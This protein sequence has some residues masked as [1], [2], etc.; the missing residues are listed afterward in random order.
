MR[1]VLAIAMAALLGASCGGGSGGFTLGPEA[2]IDISPTIITFG[3][4]PRGEV[5][6]RNITV[7]HIGTS[8][9]IK[10][11]AVIETTSPDLAVVLVEK[12][13]LQPGETARIQVEYASNHD[14]PDE[15]TLVI[16]HNLAGNPETRVP[17][18]TPGQR[19]HLVASPAVLDFG[20]VQAG[21]PRT[22]P[23]TVLNGGTAPA[24]LTGFTVAGDDDSDFQVDL[25]DGAVVEVGGQA[26]FHV[27]YAPSQRDA[28]TAILTVATDR[29]DVS[30]ELDMTGEEETPVLVTEPSLVQLGWTRPFDTTSREVVVRNDGNSNLIL[31]SISLFDAPPSLHLT[32]VPSF[33]K[34][35]RPDEATVLGIVFNPQSEHPMTGEP[36]A[37]IGIASNDEAH[38]PLNVPVFGAAGEPSITVVPGDVIDFAYV[39][40]GFTATRSVVVLNTGDS[41][42][43]VTGARLVEPTTEE[44]AFPGG[45]LLPHT[46]NPGEA[47]ELDLTFENRGGAEGSEYARF[48]INTTDPVVPEYPLNVVARRAQRPTCEAA[49]VPDLL[50]LGAY[51]PGQQG[52]GTMKVVNFGSGNC[53]YQEYDLVGCLQAGQGAAIYFECDDQIAFNPFSVAS[54]PPPGEILPPGGVLDF[55]IRFD[56]PPAQPSLYGRESFYG[57]I[58][59][60]MSDPNSSHFTYVA[61][62]GGWGRGVN[63]RAETAVPLIDVT[64]PQLNFGLVRT[65]CQSEIRRIRVTATG[66]MAATITA[67]EAPSCGDDVA[68]TAPALPA[69][70]PGFGSVFVDVRLAPDTAGEKACTIRVSN[71]SDNL[72]VAEVDLTGAGTDTTHVVDTFQQVPPPKVD[73]LFVVDDSGSMGDDQQR[74]QEELPQIVEIASQ[75]GQDI[76]LAV[77]TTD[78][79]LVKGQFKGVP[80][81]ATA[82]TDPAVFAHNLVVGTT[83]HYIE[84]GLEGA[85]LALY[86]RSV[87]TDIAC[88]NL[89]GQCPTNDGD[90]VALSCIEGFC[91]GRNFG[92]LRDD[93]QLIIIIISDEEDGSER[94]VPFYVD[95]FANLKA[96]SSGVGVV[97]HS[98][99]VTQA[100]CVGGFGTPGYRYIQATEA[101]GGHIANICGDD[102]GQ[103][104]LAVGERTFGL[105]DRFYPSAPVAPGTLIVSVNGQPCTD[106]WTQNGATGAV[107]FEAGSSCFP[108]FNDQVDLEYDILCVSPAP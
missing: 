83:G 49:F 62:E 1:Y 108:Q 44:F 78:T 39:A 29:D 58:A 30:L 47:I 37:M 102:F 77:T 12:E 13:L 100:G 27:T 25:P 80:R 99:V 55:G 8:G 88:V 104:F 22:L 52:T 103:E 97:V 46:L 85:Y 32:Q 93:A 16:T 105:T 76:H 90:G 92:F 51:R 79:V 65:D 48:F 107:V 26:T 41:A 3:D 71:D 7:H 20:I 64:P 56:A 23:V 69:T 95:A 15:G 81:Y 63:L 66:P 24:T 87:R 75:W 14:E 61:P 34:T 42:V 40:E 4:V 89:P 6:R 82:E 17:I 45:A 74:L 101:F 53:E 35:L 54:E 31:T 50:A 59:L 21:A 84:K 98:I 2:Q 38:N 18:S 73:V 57:R 68:I 11:D 9:V 106:G 86:D 60:I 5:A 36:L 10:L 19:A 33:P 96:P 43:T 72:P 67:I 91:S 70:V 94:P 28:D